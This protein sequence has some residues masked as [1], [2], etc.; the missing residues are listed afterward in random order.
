M[1]RPCQYHLRKSDSV[2][3]IVGVALRGHP[4][5]GISVLEGYRNPNE[6]WPRSA[7]PYKLVFTYPRKRVGLKESLEYEKR[8]VNKYK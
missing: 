1:F 5:S 2:K 4:S 8:E 6:G 3:T 7:H